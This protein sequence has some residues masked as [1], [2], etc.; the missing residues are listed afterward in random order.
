MKPT[1]LKL[2]L[3]TFALSL[4]ACSAN[5]IGANANRPDKAQD[6]GLYAEQQE[7]KRY[8]CK[9]LLVSDK[10]ETTHTPT[11]LVQIVPNS[12][13]SISNSSFTNLRNNSSPSQIGSFTKFTI[14]H[15]PGFFNM[16]VLDGVNE[17]SYKFTFS[18]GRIEQGSRFINVSYSYA[19]KPGYSEYRPTPQECA[20]PTPTP[21]PTP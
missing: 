17:I 6:V 21:A 13:G 5:L 10:I 1:L 11:M 18:D 9:G 3:A 15:S 20:A 16:H 8:D 12:G 2:S 19:L 7:V 4:T 14:D